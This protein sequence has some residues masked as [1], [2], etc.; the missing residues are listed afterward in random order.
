MAET[1]EEIA[2]N[3]A[4]INKRDIKNKLFKK[5]VFKILPL[6]F[7]DYDTIVSNEGVTY[8]YPQSFTIDWDNYQ[9][10][11]VYS[12]DSVWT[13]R[14]IVV[15]DLNS[16]DYI[17]CFHAGDAGGEGIVVKMEGADRYLYVK[18]SGTSLGKYLIN[19]LPS[20]LTT[21]SATSIAEVG[22]NL[23]FSY[24][25]G[26]WLVE[27]TGAPLG[28]T[29][30]RSNFTLFDD[31]FS[32][33]GTL[34]IDPSI[35]GLFEGDYSDY[36][37]KRQGLA[38]ADGYIVQKTGG[39]Y[40]KGTTPIPLS[41]NGI[42][43]LNSDGTLRDSGLINPKLM[44]SAIEDAG[45][46]CDRIESEG[47]HI[48]PNG[49][50]YSMIVYQGR[51]MSESTATG[52]MIFKEMDDESS[53]FDFSSSGIN[54]QSYNPAA[55][56]AGVFPRSG[57]GKLYNPLTGDLLDTLEK[58]CDFMKGTDIRTFSFYSSSVTIKDIGGSNIAASKLVVIQN[59][60]NSTFFMDYYSNPTC[61][62]YII[63]GSSGSR[64]QT[65]IYSASA[66]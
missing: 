59:A 17:S 8:I 53:G 40:E 1:T 27:Q 28:A 34:T 2:A 45:Y 31:T 36:V 42:M 60:N 10:F 65:E 6:R 49:D 46:P 32:R 63:Y 26:K 38:L 25:N 61:N 23:N 35:G 13:K 4:E 3:K 39:Y 18:S 66:P 44:L 54:W 55:I 58:I 12:P 9:I 16:G 7:P 33:I 22:L 64:T 48:A 14:W 20:N 56:E 62:K 21:L 5:S 47:A 37:P 15:F 29:I 57:D 50:L 30:R 52:L 11:I 43:I 19:T 51:M 24:R 41:Y